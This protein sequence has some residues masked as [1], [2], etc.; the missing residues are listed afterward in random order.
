MQSKQRIPIFL[1]NLYDI[2]EIV[3]HVTDPDQIGWIIVQ[4]NVTKGN[5]FKYICRMGELTECFEEFEL[6]KER[7]IQDAE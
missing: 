6:T 5:N 7:I 3:Y 2:G 1:S 4:I